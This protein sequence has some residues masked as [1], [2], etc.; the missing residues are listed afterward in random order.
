GLCGSE[1]AVARQAETRVAAS[2]GAGL[3]RAGAMPPGVVG[4]TEARRRITGTGS[5]IE[6]VSER[7]PTGEADAVFDLRT[8]DLPV[9]GA[10]A[11]PDRSES[12]EPAAGVSPASPGEPPV[13]E[14]PGAGVLP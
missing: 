11:P 6:A 8:I 7:H 10:G 3:D 5:S 12:P 14:V 1:F 4:V 2:P 9:S 13:P